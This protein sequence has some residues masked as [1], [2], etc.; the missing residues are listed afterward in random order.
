MEPPVLHTLQNYPEIVKAYRLFEEYGTVCY[1]MEY[2]E[3]EN[4]GER[5]KRDGKMSWQQLE[6]PIFTVLRSLQIL[7]EKGLFHRDISPGNLCGLRKFYYD[8]ECLLC[9]Q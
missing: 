5:L 9:A 1:A 8:T 4:L 7:H 3:G 2:L 6:K